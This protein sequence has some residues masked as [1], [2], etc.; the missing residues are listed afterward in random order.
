MKLTK[1]LSGSWLDFQVMLQQ[2]IE[3]RFGQ[4]QLTIFYT[5]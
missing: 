2:I 1:F 4:N 3:L 5:N